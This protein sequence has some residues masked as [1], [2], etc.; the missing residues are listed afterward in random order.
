[1][2]S[3]LICS[4][5]IPWEDNEGLEFDFRMQYEINIHNGK[6]FNLITS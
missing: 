6:N 1:M 2:F 5:D 3:A 4:V